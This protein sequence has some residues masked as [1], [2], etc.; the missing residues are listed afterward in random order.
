MQKFD[1]LGVEIAFTTLGNPVNPAILLI[2]GFG[3]THANNWVE[4]GWADFLVEAGFF[5]VMFDNRGHGQSYKLYQADDYDVDKMAQDAS[6]LMEYLD[7]GQFDVL[8]YSMGARI[9][10]FLA[11]QIPTKVRRLILGGL[12]DNIITGT[13]EVEEIAAGLLAENLSDVSDKI[14]R[15]FRIFAEHTGADRKAL[16]ACIMSPRR[17]MTKAEVLQIKQ[18]CLVAIGSV[19]DV[20]GDGNA[21][22][23]MMHDG[24]FLEIPK[25]DHM[26]ATGDKVFKLGVAKFLA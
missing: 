9:S 22:A 3:S 6:R 21:L 26:R 19:D 18:P 7:I 24:E 11:L 10:A 5:V 2:H 20:A 14:G 1:N 25:R 17:V 12:G 16:A 23:N 15:M 8:G 4:P 13:P